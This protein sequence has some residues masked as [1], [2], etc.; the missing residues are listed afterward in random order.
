M[1]AVLRDRYGTSDVLRVGDI[2][3]PTID[4][5]QVLV[6]VGA[7]GVG[8]VDW[9]LTT[10]RPYIARLALGLRRPRH[11][12]AGV[13]VAGTVEA[14]GS[15]VTRFGVGDS[16]VGTAH[17]SFAELVAA[18]EDRLVLRPDAL[19]VEQ[20]AALPVAGCAALT[21]I[22]A[23]R[24]G[25]GQRVLVLGAGGGVGHLAVQIA[26][27]RGAEV[28]AVTS[29]AKLDVVRGLGATTVVERHE[30][31]TV[32]VH[33]VILDTGGG[34]P[35]SRLRAL[36]APR[37][38]LAMIGDESGGDWIGL[39]RQLRA[40]ARSPFIHQRLL[41]IASTEKLKVLEPLVALAATG[42]VAPVVTRSAS[43]EAF[44]D[45][46]HELET[47]SVAGKAVLVP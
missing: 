6:R 33:D 30:L 47:G 29:A 12:V 10:G 22:D 24:V 4:D 20:A 25:A 43:L 44:G 7:A 37:G 9:H 39:G 42:Q 28:T 16:V 3:A 36:L 23:A 15:E 1:R 2:P 32:G 17:G 19:T 14:V 38:T 26:V 31:D 13:D 8:L 21:A 40:A 45:L 35:V 34:R 27:A 41:M 11:R 18:R 46:L 5:S